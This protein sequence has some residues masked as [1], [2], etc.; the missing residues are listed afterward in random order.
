M[1]RHKGR[2]KSKFVER[3]FSHHV[4]MMVPEFGFGAR[5]PCGSIFGFVFAVGLR[6]FRLQWHHRRSYSFRNGRGFIVDFFRHIRLLAV[7]LSDF[8]EFRLTQ[9]CVLH[10]LLRRWLTRTA[11]HGGYDCIAIRCCLRIRLAFGVV[12]DPSPSELASKCA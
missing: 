2:T 11:P 7:L 1:S 12:E 6:R 10:R 4:G 5:R 3:D 9:F 8:L